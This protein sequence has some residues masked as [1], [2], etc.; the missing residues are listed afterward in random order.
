MTDRPP[1]LRATR[2]LREEDRSHLRVLP[3]FPLPNVVLFP[4]QLLPLY[5]FEPRYR[6]MVSEALAGERL[7]GVAL[8]RPDWQEEG[9]EPEPHQVCGAGQ[10]THVTHLVGGN[11]TI[12]LHGLARVRIERTIQKEPYRLAEVTVLAEPIDESPEALK[13]AEKARSLFGQ[14]QALKPDGDLE[15]LGVLKLL[16]SPIDVFNYLCAHVEFET[17]AKQELLEMEDLRERLRRI[18]LILSRELAILN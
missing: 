10:I 6:Q 13:L 8:L 9:I 14:L 1:E 15:T 3:I 16:A 2:P 17:E 11:M 18:C 4:Q 5:I 7:L 12:L